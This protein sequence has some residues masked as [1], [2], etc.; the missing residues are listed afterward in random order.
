MR[1][2]FI[3]A[4]EA[5]MIVFHPVLLGFSAIL[6]FSSYKLWVE[7]DGGDDGDLSEN[8]IV[9]FASKFLRATESY[10]GDNFFTKV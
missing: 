4:G 5:A 1:A 8:K 3:A 2:L 10:D 6:I 7:E 9:A